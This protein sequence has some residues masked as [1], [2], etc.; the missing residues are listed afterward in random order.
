M[1]PLLWSDVSAA[2]SDASV[3]RCFSL[4]SASEK[5]KKKRKK[6]EK[7]GG[8]GEELSMRGVWIPQR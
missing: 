6:W 1:L 2:W 4:H 3:E 5:G 8:T 7:N